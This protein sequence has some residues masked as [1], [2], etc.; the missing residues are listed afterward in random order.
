VGEGLA[1]L[2]LLAGLW[3]AGAQAQANNPGQAGRW[4]LSR[5][6]VFTMYTNLGTQG[7]N[8]G[9][10]LRIQGAQSLNYPH[11]QNDGEVVLGRGWT[12]ALTITVVDC[13]NEAIGMNASQGEGVALSVKTPA[14]YTDMKARYGDAYVVITGPRSDMLDEIFPMV[15]DV[16]QDADLKGLGVAKTV[17]RVA[18]QNSGLP[19]RI[20]RYSPTADKDLSVFQ[21]GRTGLGRRPI[22]I[23]NFDFG[24]YIPNGSRSQ[25]GGAWPEDIVVSKWATRAGVTFTR[26]GMAWSYQPFDDFFIVELE[27]ENT[28]DSNG[29]GKKDLPDATLDGVYVSFMNDYAVSNAGTS[30][31]YPDQWFRFH[32]WGLDD[33]IRYSEAPSYNGPAKGLKMLFDYDGDGPAAAFDDRGDP[34]QRNILTPDCENGRVN[35]EFQSYQYPGMLPLAYQDSGPW[36]FM[37][38]DRG[39]YV[40]PT[41]DQPSAV[42]WWRI[43]SETTSEDP[44]P[45]ANTRQQMY[46]MITKP[47]IDADIKEVG[48]FFSVETF[49]PYTLKPGEKGKIVVAW[50]VGSGAGE[51]DLI[52]FWR[53]HPNDFTALADG[54]RWVAEF[55]KRAQFAYKNEYDLPDAPPDV[56]PRVENSPNA[57]NL[58]TWADDAD[59]ATNPDYAG[60]EARDV[61]GYRVYRTDYTPDGPWRLVGELKG[62]K[63][64]S[65]DFTYN[66]ADKTYSFVDKNSIAGF[67]YFYSVRTFANG[68]ATWSNGISTINDLPATAKTALNTG[69]ESGLSGEEQ[70]VGTPSSPKQPAVAETDAMNREVYVVPNPYR[71]YAPSGDQLHGYPG[72]AEIRF[73]NVPVKCEISVYSVS[74]DLM[75]FITH[76]D[77]NQTGAA[78][79]GEAQW[80]Q[81]TLTMSGQ[82]PRGLYYF[83]V[84]SLTPGSEGKIQRG[85]FVVIR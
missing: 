75:A 50:A 45:S 72:R 16:T 2:L 56:Y 42:H 49:G 58:L 18:L 65:G 27:F 77:T 7:G 55:G 73:V 25:A 12:G 41:G 35:G 10:N 43:L 4:T 17:P 44:R 37:A 82:I 33:W 63:T 69:L 11:Q 84:K 71:A 79:L 80:P 21:S 14:A 19:W 31:V 1:V 60:A 9:S 6:Q 66:A 67:N 62:L 51:S 20:D 78:R 83:T 29:D 3:A 30:W 46:D 61:A 57:T 24:R 59:G 32:A 70:R 38:R 36:A 48:Q 85:K 54:E 64:S 39:K 68:H 34:Q 74:G 26:R 47:G 52:G 53:S 13:Q 40:Q 23:D 22:K 5:A 81:L 28:G 8:G 15:H 76:D